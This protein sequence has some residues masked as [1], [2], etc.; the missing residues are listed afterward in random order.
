MKEQFLAQYQ[1]GFSENENCWYNA[2]W[3][4]SG[5]KK[6]YATTASEAKLALEKAMK[7]GQ[8]LATKKHVLGTPPFSIES[9]PDE[10]HLVTRVRIR[11]RQV[12][13]WE[14]V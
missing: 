11:R 10:K 8:E 2:I 13:E 5:Y 7:K 12:T 9:E 4:Q 1:N 6:R 3:E 14:E